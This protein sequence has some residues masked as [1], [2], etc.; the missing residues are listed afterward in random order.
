MMSFLSMKM[1][2][3]RRLSE[4]HF[5]ASECLNRTPAPQF[6]AG[7]RRN[8]ATETRDLLTVHICTFTRLHTYTHQGETMT[9]RKLA[10]SKR[11][12][13]ARIN[14]N[15]RHQNQMLKTA[16]SPRIASSVGW[17]YIVDFQ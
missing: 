4:K 6:A 2:L 3:G 13:I 11:A 1:S 12:V 8:R 15:L 17:Y 7:R 5:L 9:R 14:R 16:R 10:V